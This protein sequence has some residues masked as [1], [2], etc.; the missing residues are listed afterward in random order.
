MSWIR[1]DDGYL[2]HPK[3]RRL[4]K[5]GGANALHLWHGAL[6]WCAQHLTDG[7]IPGD[8]LGE[9]RGPTRPSAR[10]R[11]WD[12]LVQCG[13]CTRAEPEQHAGSVGAARVQ[14][15]LHDYTHYQP[16]ASSVRAA[17]EDSARRKQLSRN[18]KLHTESHC[19]ADS[20][21]Q[22][23]HAPVTAPRAPDPDPLPDPDPGPAPVGERA[24][25]PSPG[26]QSLPDP[27]S[28]PTGTQPARTP[29]SP[30]PSQL[31]KFVPDTWKP[32]DKHRVRCQELGFDLKE[33]EQSF[34]TQEFNREYSDWDRRFSRW[35]EQE[36]MTRETSAGTARGSRASAHRYGSAQQD[37]GRTGMEKFKG[38]RA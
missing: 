29:A 26:P 21:D 3:F 18:R 36:R 7:V 4:M 20:G 27:G 16:S 34:R 38:V 9:P 14:H 19:D 30:S 37:H 17:R 6:A 13:L 15:V 2:E 23:G 8:M 24:Q 11:A 25:A 12:A 35:I 22:S 5:I 10:Q 28:G 1:L 32:N 31:A 33:L